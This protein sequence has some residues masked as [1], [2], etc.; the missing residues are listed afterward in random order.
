MLILAPCVAFLVLK[1]DR[2]AW[3]RMISVPGF[4]LG[5]VI[6]LAWPVAVAWRS[7]GARELWQAEIV[8][9]TV[10]DVGYDQGWWHY[11][12]TVPW[13]LLPWTAVLLLAVG[14]SWARARRTPD[15]AD[16]FIWCWALAPIVVLSLF[17]GKHHHYIISCLTGLSPLCALGLLRLGTRV[18]TAALVLAIAGIIF[19]HARILP[20]RDRSREDRLF[21]KSVRNLVPDD[22]PLA[23][24]GGREIARHIFYVEPP[25][26]GIW[27]PEDL[28]RLGGAPFY[29]ITR[30]KLE[31]R[32]TKLGQVSVVAQSL[33]TR[34]EQTSADRFTLFRV[35]PSRISS[36]D[37]LDKP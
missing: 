37:S 34:K 32:L 33:H 5:L 1:R 8:K 21:L 19:V 26:I 17:R 36:P 10:G 7:S 4:I 3:M 29:L 2:A 31:D 25:P 24:T 6:G 13:Q 15:S 30:R 9:R 28:D 12:T 35:E 23:A 20:E 27:N 22:V 11:L 14:P 18:A 16:R